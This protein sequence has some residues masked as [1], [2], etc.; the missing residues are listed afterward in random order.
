M[1]VVFAGKVRRFVVFSVD[2][3]GVPSL[4]KEMESCGDKPGVA[5]RTEK[6][7]IRDLS[8]DGAW[9][10]EP[11]GEDLVGAST[12]GNHSVFYRRI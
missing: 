1:A 8:H 11:E 3:F 5:R 10:T 2:P 9:G 7:T 6:A 4:W 12:S